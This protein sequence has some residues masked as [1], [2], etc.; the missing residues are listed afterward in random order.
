MKDNKL[1]YLEGLRGIAAFIVVISHFVQIFYPALFNLD[2]NIIHNPIETQISKTPL[3]IL[4]N[5]NFSVCIFFVLSGFVLSYKFFETKNKQIIMSSIIRRYFRLAIPVFSSILLVYALLLFNGFY[6]DKISDL[7]FTQINTNYSIINKEFF[8]MLYTGLYGTFFA[9]DSTYNPVLWTITY[10]FFGSFL[11]YFFLLLFGVKN[12]R[13]FIYIILIFI[14]YQSYFLAFILGLLICDVYHNYNDLNLFFLKKKPV[15]WTLFLIGLFLGSYPYIDV[16]KTMYSYFN[17]TYININ[18]FML[19]HIIGACFIM[20]SILNISPIQR[21]LSHH[22]FLFLGKISFSIYLLHFTILC[23]L[24]SYLFANFYSIFS[25][26][27]S[28]FISF[29]LS[30]VVLFISSYFM[31]KYIDINAIRWSKLINLKKS[32]YHKI[33]YKENA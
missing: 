11:I 9:W 14:F 4:Y 8:S 3:N 16:T 32:K 20:I 7:T 31:Y 1:E 19:Y 28:A 24:T 29:I 2:T 26:N 10:E 15:I 6:L 5:G 25:Y 27:W 18:W 21:L 13:K 22:I 33:V 17:I 23:S 12:I 30:L